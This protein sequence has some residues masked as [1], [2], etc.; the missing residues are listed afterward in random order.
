M[1]LADPLYLFVITNFN[2]Q[3]DRLG[4]SEPQISLGERAKERMRVDSQRN[5]RGGHAR[6]GELIVN[7]RIF[8]TPPRERV[9]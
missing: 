4:R 3:N 9:A 8:A 6:Y 7:E 1:A 2:A 5:R